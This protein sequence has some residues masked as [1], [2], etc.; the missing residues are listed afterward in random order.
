LERGIALFVADR[1]L[2]W[3]NNELFPQ[4]SDENRWPIAMV[5]DL[6]CEH[7]SRLEIV[8]LSFEIPGPA[9]NLPKRPRDLAG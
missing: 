5:P 6:D 9:I 7:A 4:T 1:L 3:N 8:D 2:N